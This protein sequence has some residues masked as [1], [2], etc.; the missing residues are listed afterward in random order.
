VLAAT[1]AIV[2]ASAVATGAPP[3]GD[4]ATGALPMGAPA[5]EGEAAAAVTVTV[6]PSQSR[7]LLGT[8][9][10]ID[11]AV[12]V[13]GADAA[14]FVPV[15][16]L[17]TV[18]TLELPQA[19]AVP[20]RF[21]ARYLPPPT[22]F[23]QVA[24]LVVE[25]AGG[26]RRAHASAPIVL[27]GSTAVPFHTGPGAQVTLQIGDQTFGPVVA[28]RQGHVE[29]PVRVPPG[30][31]TGVARASDRNG[32]RETE[33]DLQLPPFPRLALLAPAAIEVGGF[34][35]VAVLALAPDGAPADVVTLALTASSGV[36]HTVGGGAPG[37]ARFVFEAPRRLDGPAVALTATAAGS[38]GARADVAV[39]LSAGPPAR[40]LATATT[41]TLIVGG[42]DGARL[43]FNARD[44]FGNP[45]DTS[46]LTAFVD[47]EPQPVTR[48]AAGTAIVT[49]PPPA[50][51]GRG[52]ISVEA[53]LGTLRARDELRVTGGPPTRV[54]ITLGRPR[55]VA[56]GHQAVDVRVA[57]LDRNG[58]PTD[59]PDLA[60]QTPDGEMRNVRG[61]HAGYYLAE[62][63]PDRV[64]E[65]NRQ[66]IAVLATP[67]VRAEAGLEVTP[68]PERVLI[69]ARA[70]VFSNLGSAVGPAA[71]GEV[72]RPFQLR[73]LRFLA[74]VEIG[75]LHGEL[76]VGV[77]NGA[78]VNLVTDQVPV[79]GLLRLRRALSPRIELGAELGAG[80][81]YA[82]TALSITGNPS[83]IVG[84]AHPLAI[85]AGVEIALPL[86]PGRLVVGARYLR[87]DIGRTSQG[88][89]IQSNSVGLLGDIGYRM[90]F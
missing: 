21:V 40:L 66:T 87:I 50:A 44:P 71:F 28:D 33:V 90:T 7:A 46:G 82:R 32:T 24:L 38:P 3:A 18:G 59:M 56:D 19:T 89:E 26:G 4:T 2:A 5:V 68:P 53:R 37:E 63:V 17:A 31:R 48:D 79:L 22:R 30:V 16:A 47:G 61:P 52:Q 70:G 58:T 81:S 62:Y 25:V 45:A 49:V 64:R 76:S 88:D 69:G 73:R 54:A 65:P 20:G 27:E 80:I 13:G 72:M 8:D 77:V 15:R 85:A 9:G 84:T 60:W 67:S 86:R 10:G 41:H 1:I 29:I 55:L 74:G 57:A 34:S 35:E 75:Y 23:P 11:V 78:H 42:S 83:E 6:T 39:A 51:Y 12:D 14:R 43:A 36:V